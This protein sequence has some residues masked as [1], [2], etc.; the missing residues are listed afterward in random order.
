MTVSEKTPFIQGLRFALAVASVVLASC[1]MMAAEVVATVK[2]EYG[3]K[4]QV[5]GSDYYIKGVVWEYTPRGENASNKIWAESEAQIRAVLDYDFSL[6]QEAGVNTIRSFSMLPPRWVTYVYDNYGIRTVV[7]PMMGRY[8]THIDGS[9]IEFT[10]YSDEITRQT[11]KAE[12]LDI[13]RAYKDVP[14]VLMFAFG[15]ESN[16]GLSW[17]S[18]EIQNLPE[19]EKETAKARYLYTLFNE[20]IAEGKEIAPGKPFTIVNG[21]IQYLE[22]IAELCPDLDLFGS[23]V[24]RGPSFTNLWKV[25]AETLDLPVVLFEFGSDAFNARQQMEDEV[26]QARI[27]RDQWLELYNKAY[28]NGE[29]G[30]SLG[31]F[32][33]QWRDEW[34][35]YRQDRNLDVHD[36]TASWSNKA[37]LFDWA[38]DRNNMNEE[39]FGIMALGPR[40]ADGVQTAEPRLAYDLL[41]RIWS[42]DPYVD[43]KPAFNKAIG[44]IDLSEADRVR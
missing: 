35:K 6:L 32:V 21:D 43:A 11:L 40:N 7:N 31:G 8:G 23:N 5:D 33:F 18:F 44:D 38:E 9:Y 12:S 27:L 24:Y 26:S 34:W 16:Y 30:N 13:V 19:A 39:W 20:V 14:G 41:S 1:N 15:N 36:E 2:D 3:W 28:G 25:V 29:E 22:L 4:L 10:N 42:M 37:Y 17:S